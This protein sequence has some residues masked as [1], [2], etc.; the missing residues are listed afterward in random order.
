[1]KSSTCSTYLAGRLA[2][3]IVMAVL[4]GICGQ[5]QAHAQHKHVHGEAKLSVAFEGVKGDIDFEINAETLL[6]RETRPKTDKEKLAD[7]SFL[8]KL[9][10]EWPKLVEL[11]AASKCK[12]TEFS[13][14]VD[15]ETEGKKNHADIEVEANILCVSP[16]TGGKIT[17]RLIEAFPKI[18]KINM[19]ILV[20]AIQKGAVLSA[21]VENIDLK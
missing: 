12:I 20:D 6:G 5:A 21:K 16:I 17:V 19:D 13:A 2:P 3:V 7:T 1:M 15:Y 18:R 14:K 11:P 8:K 4:S 9:E 10:I